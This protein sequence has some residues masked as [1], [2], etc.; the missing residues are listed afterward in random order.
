MD[1][2]WW[3]HIYRSIRWARHAEWSA[4]WET[5]KTWKSKPYFGFVS[6]YYDGQHWCFHIGPMYLGASYY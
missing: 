4:G 1:L 3:Q 5:R 6:A 2:K